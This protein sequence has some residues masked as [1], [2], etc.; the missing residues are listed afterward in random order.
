MVASKAEGSGIPGFVKVSDGSFS[1]VQ[2][3]ETMLGLSFLGVPFHFYNSF[4]SLME[5][6]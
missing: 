2:G 1:D 5:P 6:F 4:I 3:I